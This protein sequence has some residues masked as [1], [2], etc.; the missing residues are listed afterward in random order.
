[1]KIIL[2]VAI[3][4]VILLVTICIV[5]LL[6]VRTSKSKGGKVIIHGTYVVNVK[7][8]K[9]SMNDYKAPTIK[10]MR[11]V[12]YEFKN[13]SAEPLYFTSDAH[14]GHGA[15]GSLAK[16]R[17]D[18]KGLANGSIFFIVTDDL[19]DKFYYQSAKHPDMGGEVI[20]R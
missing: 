15:P 14:G 2:Q 6:L 9:F 5:H 3:L 8:G 10:L 17:K 16:S 18:F 13:E 19:P 4:I 20:I 12:Y 7:D 1:M 11:G